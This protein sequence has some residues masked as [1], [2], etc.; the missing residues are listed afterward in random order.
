MREVILNTL[1]KNSVGCE[2]GVWKGEFSQQLYNRLQPSK[3]ILL[4]PWK[5]VEQHPD[6]WYGGTWAKSQE[7]MDQI[8]EDVKEIFKGKEEVLILREFSYLSKFKI[9]HNSLDW[10]YID[11]DHSYEFVLRDLQYSL[12]WVKSGGY[13]T[14]DDY[15]KGNEIEEAVT[16]FLDTNKNKVELEKLE[17]RQFIIKVK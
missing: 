11:G 14:G 15:E 5:F 4:D 6:R 3:L 7:D 9:D 8:Y 10:T 17:G 1:P 16:F 12:L 13:I 2:I